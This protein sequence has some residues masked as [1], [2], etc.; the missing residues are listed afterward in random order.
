[1]RTNLIGGT[2]AVSRLL[3]GSIVEGLWFVTGLQPYK[4]PIA[5]VPSNQLRVYM[6]WMKSRFLDLLYCQTSTNRT[7]FRYLSLYLWHRHPM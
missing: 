6:L 1:M 4:A 3:E 5:L 2:E 7:E